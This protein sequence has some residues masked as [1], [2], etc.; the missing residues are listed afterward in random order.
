MGIVG[1]LI[2]TLTYIL[3]FVWIVFPPKLEKVPPPREMD[4]GDKKIIADLKRQLESISMEKALLGQSII[5][6]IWS[7]KSRETKMSL[8]EILVDLLSPGE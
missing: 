1:N 8:A 6:G 4:E 5:N 3:L 2:I 7:A